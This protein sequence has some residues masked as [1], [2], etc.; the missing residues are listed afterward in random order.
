MTWKEEEGIFVDNGITVCPSTVTW[1]DDKGIVDDDII[2][3]CPSNVALDEE[4]GTVV[5]DDITVYPSAATFSLYIFIVIYW[6][7]EMTLTHVHILKISIT[8]KMK[9]TPLYYFFGM[10]NKGE[11]FHS[12]ILVI[13]FTV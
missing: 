6:V 4:E 8:N 13:R 1:E 12:R 7:S 11:W 2:N 10:S 9:N 5:D 3:A